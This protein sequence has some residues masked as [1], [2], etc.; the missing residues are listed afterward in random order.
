MLAAPF[1]VGRRVSGVSHLRMLTF[2]GDLDDFILLR[3]AFGRT[4]MVSLP[5]VE[6]SYLVSPA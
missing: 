1:R 5:K 4:L 2:R 6:F 3:V